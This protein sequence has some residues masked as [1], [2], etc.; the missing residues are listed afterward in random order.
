[1]GMPTSLVPVPEVGTEL[2]LVT[3]L[4]LA[5]QFDGEFGRDAQ[6]YAGTALVRYRW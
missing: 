4:S 2:H 1:M 3:G 6:D 5:L